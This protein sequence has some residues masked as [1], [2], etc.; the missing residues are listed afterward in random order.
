MDIWHKTK[1][2]TT[3]K[4]VDEINTSTYTHKA[5]ICLTT[6]VNPFRVKALFMVTLSGVVSE[7]VNA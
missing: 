2:K 6:C 5:L 4:T 3:L 1:T 7:L